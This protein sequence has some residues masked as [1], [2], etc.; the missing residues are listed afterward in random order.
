MT[1]QWMHKS[2]SHG[3]YMAKPC[4]TAGSIKA[5]KGFTL[6]ELM[7]VVV[8]MSILAAI[9]VPSYRQYVIKNGEKQA[10]AQMKQLEIQLE[11]WRSTALTYR[12]FY[13]K[14]GL[15]SSGNPSYQYDN[16]DN[17]IINVPLGS[18]DDYIYRITLVNGAAGENSLVTTGLDNITGRTWKMVAVPNSAG[19]ASLG[20]TIVLTSW[21]IQ[22]MV[23]DTEVDIT[24]IVTSSDTSDVCGDDIQGW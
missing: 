22:C 11:R 1:T 17:T 24:K 12:G 19:S 2:K 5:E 23:S 18:G 3:Q 10:Q 15:D 8:V 9:A 20:D 13:P 6:I 16:T 4:Q 7:I 14:T 21:G